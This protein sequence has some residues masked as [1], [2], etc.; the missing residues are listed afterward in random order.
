MNV[1]TETSGPMK[2]ERK[3]AWAAST[4]DGSEARGIP[5][6]IPYI[7]VKLAVSHADNH[8]FHFTMR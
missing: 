7:R 8:L 3:A 4:L 6:P 1:V 2:L 5:T